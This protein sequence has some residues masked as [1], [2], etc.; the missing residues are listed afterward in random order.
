MAKTSSRK[1]GGSF[2]LSCFFETFFAIGVFSEHPAGITLD[3]RRANPFTIFSEK[4]VKIRKFFLFTLL[5]IGLFLLLGRTEIAR[6]LSF[7]PVQNISATLGSSL[8]PQIAVNGS[9]IFVAWE[10]GNVDQPDRFCSQCDILFRRSTDGGVTWD[11]PL[12]QPAVNLSANTATSLYPRV[13]ASGN[14]VLVFWADFGDPVEGPIAFHYRRSTD[15]GMT[16]SPIQSLHSQINAFGSPKVIFNG[17]QVHVVWAEGGLA[18]D[19]VFYSRSTDV[20]VTFESPR[21][22][23]A[24]GLPHLA[25]NGNTVAVVWQHVSPNNPN[26]WTIAF[27]DSNDEGA[28]FGPVTDLSDPLPNLGA[29]LLKSR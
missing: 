11:P 5:F 1:P 9:N 19:A 20:G 13:A 7:E 18:G 8:F 27:R 14:I 10:E 6:A 21:I 15:G 16:F 23:S 24:G 26:T 25:V 22:L 17:S 2:F 28:T 3:A 29:L 4:R 12:D